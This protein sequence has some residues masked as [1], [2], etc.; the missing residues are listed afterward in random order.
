M[1]D[2]DQRLPTG[3]TLADLR[4]VVREELRAARRREA[5]PEP[6][7]TKKDVAE[8]L[9]VTERTVDTIAAAGDL[10]KIK[11]RGCV[12]FAPS[13]V[14]SYIQQQATNSQ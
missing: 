10:P 12:R 9:D 2:D 6:L 8:V 5:A 4:A 14:E 3:A 13:A 1:P 11:V 7:L